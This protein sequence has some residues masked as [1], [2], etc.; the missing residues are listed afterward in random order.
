MIPSQRIEIVRE[1]GVINFRPLKKADEG[2]Y[3]CRAINDAG[4]VDTKGYL[5]VIGKCHNMSQYY[6]ELIYTFWYWSAFIFLFF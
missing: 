2:D 3:L 5:K 6:S 4:S 1:L